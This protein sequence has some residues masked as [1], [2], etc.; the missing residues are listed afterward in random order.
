L[1]TLGRERTDQLSF[2]FRDRLNRAHPLKMHI[3]DVGYHAHLWLSDA[4]EQSEFSERV[5]TTHFKHHHLGIF[6]R[7]EQR[8]GQ[9]NFVVVTSWTFVNTPNLV[10]D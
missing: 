9:P 4:G 6:R 2:G 1:Q 7:L 3:L 5:G 8:V 10:K